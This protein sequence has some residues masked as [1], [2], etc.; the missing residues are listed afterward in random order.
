MDHEE[1]K[2]VT[3]PISGMTCASCSRAIETRVGKMQGVSIA[4]VNLA[5]ETAVFTY[6]PEM[7][8]LSEIKQ[9]ILALGYTPREVDVKE[10]TDED[11]N[12][13]AAEI[14]HMWRNFIWS[15]LFTIPL[16]YIAMGPMLPIAPLPVPRF[17]HPMDYPLIYAYVQ[18]LLL[19]PVVFFGR[20]FYTVG[21]RALF[22]ASPNMDSLVAIGT[23]AAVL[24]SLGSTIRIMT[25]DF[26]GVNQLYFETAAVILT[27]IMLGK[28]LEA[29]SKGKTSE[30]IKRLMG[31]APKTAVVMHGDQQ[32][33]LPIDEVEPGDIVLTRPGEKIALDGIVQ[34]GHSS[35]DES[36]LTGES[37]PIEKNVGDKVIGASLN[38]TGMLQVRVTHVGADTALSRIIQLVE[39]AQGSKAPIARLA[40]II[41]GWF[42]PIVMGIALLVGLAWL[43]S[44]ES[45][46]FSLSVFIAILVIACPC[47]L[48][49]ATPTA[50]MV[51]SG[52]GAELGILI[53]G[54]EA[55]ENA[56][57]TTTVIFDKTG[58]LTQGAPEVTE[59]VPAAGFSADQVLIYAA[60]AEFGSEHPLGEAIIKKAEQN[61]LSRLTTQK[62]DAIA[63]HGISVMVDD[64]HVLLGNERLMNQF[65]VDVSDLLP[66]F[67]K[68]ADTGNTPM[69]LSVDG[70]AAGVIAAADPLK[71]NSA[72]AVRELQHMGI[73]VVMITG[74][75]QKTAEAVAKAVGINDVLAQVLPSDKADQ[76][77]KLQAT[78][79]IVAMVGDGIN[80]APALAQADVGIAIGSGT[81][82]AMASAQIV[83]MKDELS[84]VATAFRL[85]RA[86]IRNIK[87]N[88]FWAFIYN[89]IGIPI[90]AG[91]L[92]LFGGPMLSPVFAAAAMSLSSV[93]VVS[94][95]LRLKR[96]KPLP[97]IAGNHN[98]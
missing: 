4:N 9:K 85:S 37:I 50:I 82:V 71:K 93:T 23:S 83:L 32:I 34:E 96:F 89:I 86:T 46:P 28:N 1:T 66:D 91:L 40:D 30:A 2:T 67:N 90:A 11:A 94:N 61:G 68:L 6:N 14:K 60:S 69:L 52:K 31:L 45:I 21:F 79:E 24:Y 44:G 25:G 53:K 64:H 62:F 54:G 56:Y 43:I 88:L 65:K 22:H 38:K 27:L 15:A 7:V 75:H 17:M 73:K 87:Q 58:T 48:G 51:G 8:R 36:M 3:V 77:K 16:L 84:D 63:G 5:T 13:K 29:V 74:D 33:T 76:V 19:I 20:K 81:D 12:R 72:N 41:S 59:I 55:L 49:L 39:E 10:K 97:A 35:V 95:A 26:A 57:K 18:I 92:H 78:G 80:D 42:V 98:K 70:K 47:A